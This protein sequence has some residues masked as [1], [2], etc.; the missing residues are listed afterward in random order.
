ML[1]WSADTATQGTSRTALGNGVAWLTPNRTATT[2]GVRSSSLTVD[3]VAGNAG[4][5]FTVCRTS[6]AGF[7]ASR[8]KD[9][10][11][12]VTRP[13]TENI[14]RSMIIGGSNSAAS[15][16]QPY[17]ASASYYQGGLKMAGFGSA[18]TVAERD[19]IY[20]AFNAFF[21]AAAGFSA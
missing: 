19:A 15:G 2:F 7:L 9:A 13:Q 5:M 21:T 3:P 1:A 20:D 12:N 10:F 6:A 18:L 16:T 11:V 17:P 4:G 14:T 8:N